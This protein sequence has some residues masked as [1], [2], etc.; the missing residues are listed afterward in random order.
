M[1]LRIF[2]ANAEKI[3]EVVSEDITINDVRNALDLMSDAD[4]NG[5][6]RIILYEHNL[7]PTFFDLSTGMAGEVLQKFAIY[8][9]KLA[10]V[11]GFEK[12]ESK[13][14]RA[15]MIESNRS[16]LVFFAPDRET[17]IDSM[18]A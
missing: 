4:Y 10:I 6:R 16:G 12:Y 8:G 1:A 9:V 17:A 2:E 11:G 7:D 5:A 3:A 18:T 13:S 15:F 14:L